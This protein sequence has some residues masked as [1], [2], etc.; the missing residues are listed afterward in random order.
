MAVQSVGNK[1]Y[2]GTDGDFTDYGNQILRFGPGTRFVLNPV[3]IAATEPREYAAAKD[4]TTGQLVW[5]T[6]AQNP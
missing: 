4:P 1:T 5:R 3:P 2:T 6:L